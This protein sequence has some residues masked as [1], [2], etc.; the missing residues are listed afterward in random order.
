MLLFNAFVF[1][2]HYLTSFFAAHMLWF[3]FLFYILFR[4]LPYTR[5]NENTNLY[6]NMYSHC[7]ESLGGLRTVTTLASLQCD[8]PYHSH[9]TI[10]LILW[11]SSLHIYFF[12]TKEHKKPKCLPCDQAIL[13]N[14]ENLDLLAGPIWTKLK[15]YSFK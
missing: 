15:L 12:V 6:H 7:D 2:M 5:T 14:L 10:H 11:I 3:S 8:T 1:R 4:I 13:W 9:P